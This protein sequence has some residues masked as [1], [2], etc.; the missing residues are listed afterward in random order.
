MFSRGPLELSQHRSI[1]ANWVASAASAR[2]ARASIGALSAIARHASR[3][4]R[5]LLGCMPRG[6]ERRPDEVIMNAAR[7]AENTALFCPEATMKGVGRNLPF[8]QDAPFT[9]VAACALEGRR[10]FLICQ[11]PTL[12]TLSRREREAIALYA[13]GMSSKYI[14]VELRIGFSTARV[15]LAR[16]AKKLGAARTD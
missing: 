2:A 7:R 11:E 12:N 6:E 3:L 9:V 16:A 13:K 5:P 10:Y 15:L 4:A 14:A 8:D 1:R